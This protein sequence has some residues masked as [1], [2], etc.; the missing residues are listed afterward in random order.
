MRDLVYASNDP[1]GAKMA[2]MLELVY[3]DDPKFTEYV[4]DY[5]WTWCRGRDIRLAFYNQ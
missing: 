1:F 5:N 4:D 2:F 3:R